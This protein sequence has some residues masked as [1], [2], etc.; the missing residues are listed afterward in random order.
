[1]EAYIKGRFTHPAPGSGAFTIG[2]DGHYGIGK[3]F[4]LKRLQKQLSM[5]H[6]VAFVDA[7]ADDTA[8]DPL[9]AII[10][11]ITEAVLTKLPDAKTTGKPS[12][13]LK[14]RSVDL[15]KVGIKVSTRAVMA[16]MLTESGWD[17]ISETITKLAD[18][19]A[20]L[21]GKDATEDSPLVLKRK[22]ISEFHEK[23][24]A[25]TDAIKEEGLF[26]LPLV[27]I[28]DEL[29]R[30]RPTY[31]IKL[32]EETKHFFD[33]TSVVILYGMSRTALTHTVKAVYGSEF[34]ADEYLQRFVRRR[35]SL[36][37]APLSSF[38]E[39]EMLESGA[40]IEKLHLPGDPDDI[41]EKRA[42]HARYLSLIL[43]ENGVSA[44]STQAV[45]EHLFSFLGMWDH[46]VPVQ[47]ALLAPLAI[48]HQK[49]IAHS[50][51]KGDSFTF[52][53]NIDVPTAGELFYEIQAH[54]NLTWIELINQRNSQSNKSGGLAIAVQEMVQCADK[55][56]LDK[57]D[58]DKKIP[59]S[60]YQSRVVD[61][62]EIVYFQVEKT[63]SKAP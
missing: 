37:E 58:Y 42:R 2:V 40:P 26:E 50:D 39:R 35:F 47:L 18:E 43:A 13:K 10:M 22:L 25:L 38:I 57:T 54:A 27:L 15:L 63:N 36:A 61:V 56:K 45:L 62:G 32:L 21:I 6:P 19:T 29:D 52:Q 60:E 24:S 23:L 41:E 44:R 9:S 3:S 33:S 34:G 17:Q 11:S 4:F 53:F 46:P 12:E 59:L 31:A 49:G 14:A 7:W 8:D 48:C 5:N 28:I 30:C 16:K 51:F 55:P 1:M 20:D